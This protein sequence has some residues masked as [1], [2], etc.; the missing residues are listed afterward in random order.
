MAAMRAD[1]LRERL[2]PFGAFD[3]AVGLFTRYVL[4]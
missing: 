3:A 2:L 4:K 1:S